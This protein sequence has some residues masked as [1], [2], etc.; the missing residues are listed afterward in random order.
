[1]ALFTIMCPHFSRPLSVRKCRCSPKTGS[2]LWWPPACSRRSLE[3][4]PSDE[5]ACPRR[6]QN[7]HDGSVPALAL[8][9]WQQGSDCWCRLVTLRGRDLLGG[10]PNVGSVYLIH[11]GVPVPGWVECLFEFLSE[12]LLCEVHDGVESGKGGGG[13][14]SH[15]LCR[16]HKTNDDLPD[17]VGWPLRV[18][19]AETICPGRCGASPDHW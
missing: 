12:I 6:G 17:G 9:C 16:A 8:S 11:D 3:T 14:E 5:L 13:G 2:R 4:W 18:V 15:L 10:L 19:A 7:C 1:M